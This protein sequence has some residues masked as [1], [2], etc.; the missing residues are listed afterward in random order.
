LLALGTIVLAIGG[1]TNYP[2]LA[3][4]GGILVALYF[5]LMLL[6]WVLGIFGRCQPDLCEAAAIHMTVLAPLGG[7]LGL[8]M[9][10]FPCVNNW[11]ALTIL[12]V[13]LAFWGP[14][15]ARCLFKE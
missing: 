1:C 14:V 5:V 12:S 9:I 13:V 4:I 10:W 3:W 2:I 7:I 6:W 11:F 8:L 15:A